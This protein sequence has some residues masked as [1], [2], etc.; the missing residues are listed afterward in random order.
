MHK[1]DI[2]NFAKGMLA[3]VVV[4]AAA[5]CVGKMMLEDNKQLSRGSGK[6]LKAMGDFM[7]GIHTMFK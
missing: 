6:A 2:A 5:T 1:S 7:D 3:G 4:G